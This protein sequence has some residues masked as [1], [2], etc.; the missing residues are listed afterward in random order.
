MTTSF[1][2]VIP[3]NTIDNCK[4]YRVNKLNKVISL[5]LMADIEKINLTR[6]IMIYLSDCSV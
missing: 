1:M 4:Q 6:V 5:I 3:Y 2:N